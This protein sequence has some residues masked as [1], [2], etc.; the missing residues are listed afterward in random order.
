MHTVKLQAVPRFI[1]YNAREEYVNEGSF[2]VLTIDRGEVGM[3][4]MYD[5]YEG[6]TEQLRNELIVELTCSNHGIGDVLEDHPRTPTVEC[7]IK[8]MGSKFGY[9]ESSGRWEFNDL[10]DIATRLTKLFGMTFMVAQAGK[11]YAIE[12]QIHVNPNELDSVLPK[13]TKIQEELNNME[14]FFRDYAKVK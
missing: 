3:T 9:E 1:P 6:I 11:N 8:V 14:N 5:F 4:R 2:T 13:L 10:Q 7:T 12:T